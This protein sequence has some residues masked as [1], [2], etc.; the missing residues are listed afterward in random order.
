MHIHLQPKQG[1]LYDLLVA[2]GTR[3]PTIIGF[4]GAK[5]G[6]KSAGSDNC[7]LLLAAEIGNKYPGVHITIVRRVFNDLKTNHIDRIFET[8]PELR[9]FYTEKDGLKLR[10][11][12]KI[13]FA[14]AVP[15]GPSLRG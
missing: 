13:V 4:G 15:P 8:Y 10:N 1:E 6:G 12:S 7:T 9:Q 14:Y 5:G 2:T 11:G 3:A